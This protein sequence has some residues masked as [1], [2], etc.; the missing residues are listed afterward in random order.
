[1]IHQKKRN[2][3]LVVYKSNNKATIVIP[4]ISILECFGFYKCVLYYIGHTM[5]CNTLYYVIF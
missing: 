2:E 4:Y 3:T 5:Q 1:M